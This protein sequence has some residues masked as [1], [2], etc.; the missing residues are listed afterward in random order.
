[1][2]KSLPELREMEAAVRN[3]LEGDSSD[4]LKSFASD[5]AFPESA[6]SFAFASACLPAVVQIPE[7]L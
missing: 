7:T 3:E 5:V 1:M 4:R 2:Q 6:C